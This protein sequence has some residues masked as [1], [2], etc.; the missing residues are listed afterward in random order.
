MIAELAKLAGSGGLG[1]A[2][3]IV[4]MYS[5]FTPI[6]SHNELV[7]KSDR[8]YILELVDKARAEPAGAFKDTIC[9]SLHEAVA[10]LC[11]AAHDDA[12]CVDRQMWFERA[13]C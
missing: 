2:L 10:E 12:I 7:A 8:S 13:G 1:A 11:A 5:Q 3:P 4:L 9:K 6:A